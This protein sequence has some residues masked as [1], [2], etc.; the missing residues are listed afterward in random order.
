MIPYRL[1]LLVIAFG[2]VLVPCEAR[3]GETVVEIKARF[4]T[5][6][7]IGE[8][9]AGSIGEQMMEF[10]KSGIDIRVIFLKGVAQFE[11]LKNIDGTAFTQDEI[12][13]LLKT[14]ADT[15]KWTEDTPNDVM[16]SWNRTDTATAIYMPST[17]MLSFATA[18]YSTTM[19]LQPG[20]ST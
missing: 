10:E 14:E 8:P 16:R 2:L 13:A 15:M 20:L 4:G 3:L 18:T 7:S 12:D 19:A 9:P 1:G 17:K 11:M 5:P 6:I